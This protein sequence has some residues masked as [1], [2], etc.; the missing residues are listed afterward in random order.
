MIPNS[1]GSVI[2]GHKGD[3]GV[4]GGGSGQTY[5]MNRIQVV[6]DHWTGITPCR[7]CAGRLCANPM[8]S[9]IACSRLSGFAAALDDYP[10]DAIGTAPMGDIEGPWIDGTFRLT[11]PMV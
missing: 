1:A 2:I 10:I 4:A 9:K 8:D 6:E 11:E 3:A 5:F 7:Y